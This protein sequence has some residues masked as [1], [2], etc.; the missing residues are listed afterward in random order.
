MNFHKTIGYLAA[1]LLIV[2]IGAPDSFAQETKTVDISFSDDF[3][4]KRIREGRTVT[5]SAILSEEPAEDETV[6][7]SLDLEVPEGDS[8]R[9]DVGTNKRVAVGED[10]WDDRVIFNM[11][12]M[13]TVILMLSR[14]R[15]LMLI[16]P[17]LRYQ[18]RQQT[19]SR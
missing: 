18:G 8:I 4:L 19:V 2:G 1:L 6:T 15:R 5:V 17:K 14:R 10:W 16:S 12:L 7:L 11:C 3:R 9:Y 13:I